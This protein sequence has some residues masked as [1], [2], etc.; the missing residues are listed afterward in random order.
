[1]GGVDE[2][3]VDVRIDQQL[4]GRDVAGVG[5]LPL[6]RSVGQDGD[7]REGRHLLLEALLDVEGVGIA[8]IAEDLQHLALDRAVAV[9]QQAGN[10]IGGDIA[11]LDRAGDRSEVER[12]ALD[13]A[14]EDDDRNS[15]RP[16]PL[17]SRHDRV[18]IDRGQDDRR[19]LQVDDVVDLVELQI[20]PVLGIERHDL[21]A[22]LAEEAG[23]RAHRFGLELVQ[24]GRHQVVDLALGLGH[25]RPGA[26]HQHQAGDERD[27]DA[28]HH[29]HDHSSLFQD[30]LPLEITTRRGAS[31]LR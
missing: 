1:M 16:C 12:R 15:G 5:R 21:V 8:G 20:G 22:D 17:D 6:H 7:V 31:G 3:Q 19:R 26:G 28:L 30:C 11:D 9:L 10:R 25:R 18:E 4:V 23:D 13:L 14:V 2:D 27:S 24:Q 29:S